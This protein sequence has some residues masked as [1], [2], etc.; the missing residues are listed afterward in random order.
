MKSVTEVY[1]KRKTSRT[2]KKEIRVGKT[3]EN[4]KKEIL[5]IQFVKYVNNTN[6]LSLQFP[7]PVGTDRV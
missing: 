7:C 5:H 4:D 1:E 3:R 6:P 2:K